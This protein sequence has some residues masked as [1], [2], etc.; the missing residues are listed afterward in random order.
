[1]RRRSALILHV[2]LNLGQRNGWCSTT[3]AVLAS[4]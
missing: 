4:A 2:P 3:K 1:M